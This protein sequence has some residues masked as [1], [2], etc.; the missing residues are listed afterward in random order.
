MTNSIQFTKE[1]LPTL[2][3]QLQDLMSYE[4]ELIESYYL[5]PCEVLRDKIV[6]LKKKIGTAKN[7]ISEI[8]TF[9]RLLN[10]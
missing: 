3:T 8:K 6:D 1:N 9:G 7:I 4:V 10:S 2:E 5:S